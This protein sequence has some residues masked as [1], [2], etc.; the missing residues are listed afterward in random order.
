MP[1]VTDSRYPGYLAPVT[2]PASDGDWDDA[3]HAMFAGITGLPPDL[4]RPKWQLEPGNMPNYD[5]DWMAFGSNAKEADWDA[6]VHHIDDGADGYDELRRTEVWEY[7]ATFYGPNVDYYSSVLRDG[8]AIE[9]NRYQLLAANAAVVEVQKIPLS[10]ELVNQRWVGRADVTVVLRR[11]IIRRYNV[12]H[13][14]RARG[15]V[16]SNTGVE[17]TFDTANHH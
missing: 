5:L 17:S 15:T 12:L 9:Q 11:R 3:L 2:T 10:P 8:L 6:E 4:V 16:D 13:L 14:L 7:L 1:F